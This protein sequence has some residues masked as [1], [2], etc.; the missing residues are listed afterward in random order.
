[1]RVFLMSALVI[2]LLCSSQCV[3][4]PAEYAI[5]IEKD[6]AATDK[7]LELL[8]G[9]SDVKKRELEYREIIARDQEYK[10]TIADAIKRGGG[11]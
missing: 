3:R 10:R 7:Q 5:L 8:N 4:L 11:N 2:T 9:I 6:A 1:M